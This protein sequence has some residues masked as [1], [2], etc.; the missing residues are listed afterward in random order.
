MLPYCYVPLCRGGALGLTQ[1]EVAQ[2]LGRRQ[3][4]VAHIVSG[5]RRVDLVELLDLAAVVGR[6][7][8][9]PQR[10]AEIEYAIA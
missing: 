2:A 6:S 9:L 8:S 7:L 5:K 1:V 10:P 3:P 4:F